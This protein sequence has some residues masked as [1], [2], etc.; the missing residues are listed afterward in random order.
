M[1]VST[2]RLTN[3]NRAYP[4]RGLSK[5]VT[6]FNLLDKRVKLLVEPIYDGIIYEP[7]IVRQLEM[8]EHETRN[9]SIS[10]TAG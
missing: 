2:P 9:F 8:L 3:R 1:Q 4:S 5:T 10:K 7:A 6:R